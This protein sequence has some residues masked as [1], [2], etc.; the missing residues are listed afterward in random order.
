MSP[1]GYKLGTFCIIDSKTRLAGLSLDE[2][3]TLRD[4][5]DL[6]VKEMVDRR[7]RSATSENPTQLIAYTAHDLMTPLT[8]VQLS[9]SLLKEDEQVQKSLGEH[10]MELLATATNCSDLMVR[11]CQT[12]VDTLRQESVPEVAMKPSSNSPVTKTIDLVKS[13]HMLLDTVPKSIPVII[14]LDESVPSLILCD[15]LKLFRSALNLISHG[16]SGTELGSVL[17]RISCR[18]ECLYF[19]CFDTGAAIPV[20]NYQYL[21]KAYPD[22]DGHLS[23]GLSSVASLIGSLDGEF[24]FQPRGLEKDGTVSSN[25]KGSLFWFSI[26]LNTPNQTEVSENSRSRNVSVLSRHASGSENSLQSLRRRL[27]G[28]KLPILPVLATSNSNNSV[29]S[30]GG[31]KMAI[32][33]QNQAQSEAVENSCFGSVFTSIVKE[34]EHEIPVCPSNGRQ[35]SAMTN[36]LASSHIIRKPKALVIDDSLVVRKSISMVLKK[37]GFEVEQAVDGMEGLKLLKDQLFDL[38]LC[39]FLMPVMDGLDCVKQYRDW[40]KKERPWFSQYIIGISA[41][42]TANDGDRGLKAGMDEFKPKPITMNL[43]TEIKHGDRL[44]QIAKTLDEFD[45]VHS[46]LPYVHNASTEDN[47]PVNS[48]P[49]D[50]PAHSVAKRKASTNDGDSVSSMDSQSYLKKLKLDSETVKQMGMSESTQPVCLIATENLTPQSSDIQGRFEESGWSVVVVHDI[51]DGLQLLKMRNWDAVLL[52]DAVYGIFAAKCVASFREWEG[53]SRVN[54]QRNLFIVCNGDIPSP[55]DRRSFVLPPS[56]ADG[57]LKK[58]VVWEDFQYLLRS[59]KK[60]GKYEIVVR[61]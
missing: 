41:H 38:T 5:A 56:G 16:I 28:P 8:G 43:L 46:G 53:K 19:E 21:F 10:Q 3:A 7:Q 9:L 12:A 58:P 60:G 54:K 57:V 4:L 13:L 29:S 30:L 15:D 34:T 52:D 37:L 26:P 22:E 6:T 20:E 25:V 48:T 49:T 27:N 11:I 31:R 18:Q 17:L 35:T 45:R 1:E 50:F 44:K 39:D 55:M 59:T 36:A 47:S 2:Q 40:E 32:E 23:L 51:N 61:K 33:V 24:G 14:T 42:A